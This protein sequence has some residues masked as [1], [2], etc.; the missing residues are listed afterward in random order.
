MG[1]VGVQGVAA[2]QAFV[3][4]LLYDTVKNALEYFGAVK[5]ANTVLAKC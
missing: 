5:T 2:N 3:E 4:R 1:A